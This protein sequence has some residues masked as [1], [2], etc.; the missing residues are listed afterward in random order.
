LASFV[1]AGRSATAAV[2]TST[3]LII[4]SDAVFAVIFNILGW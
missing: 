1:L 3:L 4:V 2:V